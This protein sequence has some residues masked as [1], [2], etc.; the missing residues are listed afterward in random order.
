MEDKPPYID[1]HLLR[2]D[3][4]KVKRLLFSKFKH[5]AQWVERFRHSEKQENL[6]PQEVEKQ[7]VTEF[8][9]RQQGILKQACVVLLKRV[10]RATFFSSCLVVYLLLYYP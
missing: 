7:L 10:A 6:S 5:D 1:T 9:N 3:I 8:E 2:I 4:A